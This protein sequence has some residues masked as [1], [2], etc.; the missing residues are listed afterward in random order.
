MLKPAPEAKKPLPT[1]FDFS[2]YR[3]AD[4]EAFGRNLVQLMD[5][6]GKVMSG[7][8]AR[9]DAGGSGPY[10]LTN[11][12][13]EAGKLFSEIAQHWMVDPARLLEKQGTLVRDYLQLFS[14]TMRRTM[15]AEVLPVAEPEPGDN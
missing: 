14:S 10:S 5:E 8:L 12:L 15:G 9:A 3:I 13:T 1:N 7:L 2:A 6:G 11:E 4:P